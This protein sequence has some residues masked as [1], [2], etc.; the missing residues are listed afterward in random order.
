MKINELIKKLQ[1]LRDECGNV[2]VRVDSDLFYTD[3]HRIDDVR[4]DHDREVVNIITV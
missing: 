1:N 2:T 3:I 4:Y